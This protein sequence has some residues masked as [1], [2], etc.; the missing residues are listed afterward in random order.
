ME[1][2]TYTHDRDCFFYNQDASNYI[3]DD[4]SNAVRLLDF[5]MHDGY[6]QEH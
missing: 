3:M 5:Y 2:E 4:M 6:F 1:Q